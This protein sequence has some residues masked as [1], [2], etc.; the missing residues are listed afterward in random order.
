M[1]A[2]NVKMMKNELA[3]QCLEICRKKSVKIFCFFYRSLF[4]ESEKL[5]NSIRPLR[6]PTRL[7]PLAFLLKSDFFSF[8]HAFFQSSFFVSISKINFKTYF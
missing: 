5:K 8:F 4:T 2:K 3:L 1:K 6:L 7:R